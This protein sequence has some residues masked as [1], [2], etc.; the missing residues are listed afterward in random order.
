MSLTAELAAAARLPC[1]AELYE[2]L[3]PFE[4][5]VVTM[6]ATFVCLGAIDHYLGLLADALA[7]GDRAARHFADA[8]TLNARI[9]AIPWS[10]RTLAAAAR[11]VAR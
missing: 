5:R 10:R 2:T 6:D 8:I 7:L 4:G 11:R 3:L 9:G 1:A